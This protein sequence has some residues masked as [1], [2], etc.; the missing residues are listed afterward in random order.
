MATTDADEIDTGE[1]EPD[2]DGESYG[3]IQLV[4]TINNDPAGEFHAEVIEGIPSFESSD[5]GSAESHLPAVVL[6]GNRGARA[7]NPAVEVE[8]GM[9]IG[10]DG[11][12]HH[13]DERAAR[14]FEMYVQMGE[15]RSLRRLATYIADLEPRPDGW[16]SVKEASILAAL[17]RYS[18]NFAWR[19]RLTM[20]VARKTAQAVTRA[21]SEADRRR[22][23]RIANFDRLQRIG[24]NIIVRAGLDED[25]SQELTK[26]EARALLRDGINLVQIGASGER[27]EV[28]E[29]LEEIM[30]DIPIE[31]MDAEQLSVY[32]ERL[33]NVVMGEG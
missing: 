6:P 16:E 32:I 8:P 23:N 33:R 14:A 22:A 20:L 19:S 21:R 12:Q 11:E 25:S 1:L 17:E 13:E 26:T 29:G 10:N 15:G 9:F 30:P 3:T 7:M 18:A 31:D 24:M 5:E 4:D 27:L 28:G 2:D